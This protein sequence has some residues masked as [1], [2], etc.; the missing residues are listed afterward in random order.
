MATYILTWNHIKW[1]WKDFDAA[2]R[3]VQVGKPLPDFWST[4]NNRQLRH[5]A[6]TNLTAILQQF[7]LKN[8]RS[9]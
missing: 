9:L 2:I 4:G 1:K 8:V 6:K 7:G 5:V 3:T